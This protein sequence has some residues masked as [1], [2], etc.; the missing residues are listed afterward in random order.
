MGEGAGRAQ[1]VRIRPLARGDWPLIERLFGRNGACGGC[2]CMWW[3]VPRGGKLWEQCKGER[4]RRAFR[5]LV[6]AGRVHACIALEA[7]EPVG[8]CCIG[9]RKDFPRLERV[10]ALQTEWDERTWSVVCFFVRAGHRG[11]GIGTALLR[12]AVK[13]ARRGRARRLEGYPVRG[14]KGG[15]LIP[16]A[17]AWTGTSELF[18]ANAFKDA[19]PPGNPREILV[20]TFR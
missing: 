16:A 5:K 18:T 7:D 15:V 4:N 10:R 1:R 9:P 11:Q 12:E 13:L 2:W 20:R 17:F 3:R 14:R 6:T 8:W 19:T